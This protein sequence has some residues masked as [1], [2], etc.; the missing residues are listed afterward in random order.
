[1]V[2]AYADGTSETLPLW[3]MAQVSQSSQ[4]PGTQEGETGVPLFVEFKR[5]EKPIS[6]AKL[7]IYC[8]MHW[9][10]QDRDLRAYLL[11]PPV[12]KDAEAWGVAAQA[13]LLDDGLHLQP[14]VQGVH[15]YVDGSSIGDFVHPGALNYNNEDTFDPAIYGR[16]PTDLNRLPHL[17]LGK[18][19]NTNDNWALVRS[20]YSGEGF[21]PLA[22][23]V[24]AMRLHMPAD[25]NAVDGG[26]N[27]YSGTTATTAMIF[28]PEPVFGRQRRIFVR[29]YMRLGTPYARKP[30]DRKQVFQAV[31]AP[32]TWSTMAGKFGIGASHATSWGGVSGTS[33]GPYGW[34]MR[35]SWY[36]CDAGMNGPDEGGI[37]AG[38]HLFD[39]YYR[40][41]KGY[42][43][44]G[45]DGTPEQ[46]RWGQRGGLG[47]MLYAG[48]WYCIE[49]ELDLN[50]ISDAAPGFVPDGALRTWIDGR[51]AY[52]RAGMV[53]R[54]G[55]VL[56]AAPVSNGRRPV[57]DLGV[58]GLWL[59]WFHGGKT[60]N[61]VD[62]TTFFTGLAYGTEYIGPMKGPGGLSAG[63]S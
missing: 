10:G 36:D 44:G 38:Y 62:R 5:P 52:D 9:S 11:D 51:L 20:D 59:D 41:P 60:L 4:G 31:G 35:G 40:N 30:S 45:P 16:G 32:A 2:V 17:G 34:Q 56:Q 43:Y 39:Y 25:S 21:A 1:M 3:C 22:P 26:V 61:S 28:L 37:A 54:S 46:E 50:T 12:N 53:F 14:G 58:I 42:N 48:H 55:P 63:R 6:S 18:W 13:G 15:R 24:G 8:T 47:G 7:R 27:G 57:R 29:Y 33:G 19:I 23:G 49:T